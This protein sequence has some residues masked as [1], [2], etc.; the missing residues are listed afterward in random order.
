MSL[1]NVNDVYETAQLILDTLNAV[2]LE[3]GDEVT[4]LPTRQF[5]MAGGPGSQPHDCEQVTVSLGQLYTGTPGNPSESPVNCHNAP[6]S[7]AY[8]VEVVR[9]TL[10]TSQ[11]S[12][13]GAAVP[14]EMSPEDENKLAKI[15]MQDARLML[16][17]GLM[18]G[19]TFIGSVADAAAGAESGGYQAMT[20]TVITGV[21]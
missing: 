10:P 11:T 21:I 12:R 8:H 14:V 3:H 9:R 19:D 6:F 4:P 13:R 17:A 20:M 18:V 1:E 5:V 7:A 15:Q 16:Q 2:Y